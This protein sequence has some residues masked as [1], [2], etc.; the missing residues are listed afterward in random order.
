MSVQ[1]KLTTLKNENEML[2]FLKVQTLVSKIVCPFIERKGTKSIILVYQIF[3]RI[4][5]D[6]T[7]GSAYCVLDEEESVESGC[8]Q[9]TAFL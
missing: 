1:C 9:L 2:Y 7:T 4:S 8:F 3:I 5:S 6:I